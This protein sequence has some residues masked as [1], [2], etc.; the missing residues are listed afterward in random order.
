SKRFESELAQAARLQNGER[1]SATLAALTMYDRGEYL[2]GRRSEWTDARERELSS[3]AADARFEAA[4][5]A[6]AAGDYKLAG[7]LAEQV[8]SAEPFHEAGWRLMMRIANMLGDEN[9]VIRA[10]HECERSLASVGAQP[11]PS[12]RELLTHLRR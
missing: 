2:P 8:L 7:L 6:F 10:F 9:A 5:L 12:T 4:E 11:A 1:L 3:A